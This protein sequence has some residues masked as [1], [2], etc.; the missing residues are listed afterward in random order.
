MGGVDIRPTLLKSGLDT[1]ALGGIWMEIDDERKGKVLTVMLVHLQCHMR[2][3]QIDREQL[4]MILA[5]ISN[6]QQNKKV[7]LEEID[8]DAVPPPKLQGVEL[9]RV[10]CV[11]CPLVG[12]DRAHA[13]AGRRFPRQWRQMPVSVRWRRRVAA[14]AAESR[15]EN[16]RIFAFQLI[17]TCDMMAIRT[18]LLGITDAKG[19]GGRQLEAIEAVLGHGR[20]RIGIKL[21]KGNV[22][23]V[24]YQAHLPTVG[25][26]AC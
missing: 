19:R 4:H 10:A 24:G 18:L 11:P 22:V 2:L 25:A 23:T 26:I 20:P 15:S 17:D 14:S 6:Y 3:E 7:S 8:F 9:P 12:S 13:G 5:L 21:H 16:I 1:K